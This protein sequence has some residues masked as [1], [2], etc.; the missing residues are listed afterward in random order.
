MAVYSAEVHE[1]LFII[2]FSQ[3][4][5]LSDALFMFQAIQMISIE[6]HLCVQVYN[7]CN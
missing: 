1:I 4:N 3:F 2:Y 5:I 7:Y 6:I